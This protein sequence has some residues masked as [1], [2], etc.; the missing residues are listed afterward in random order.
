MTYNEIRELLGD[1][2]SN[3]L[4]HKCERISSDLLHKPSMDKVESIF[5]DSNRSKKVISNIKRLY[6]SG[7]LANTGYL[8]ILPVDQ[9]IEH[10]AIYS[11]YNNPIYFDPEN[12]VKL[13]IEGGTNGVVSTFGALGILSKK[14][15]D[16]IPF[17][18]KI[19][20]NELLS[21]PNMH[22][23]TMFGLVSDAYNMGATAIG[24]T[25]YFGSSDSR[26][27]IEEVSEA[28]SIAHELGMATILWCYTRNKEFVIDGVDYH[29][30]SDLSSQAIHLGATLQA[31]II[32]QKLPTINGGTKALNSKSE[33]KYSKYNED[34]DK[35]LVTENPIDMTRLQVAASYMGRIDVINSGGEQG[36]NDK[37]SAVRAAVINKR[38]GGA[39]M[40]MGRKAYKKS[41]DEGVE[42]LNMVQDVYLDEQITLS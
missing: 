31:D 10:S 12:V 11:F 33:G 32:K 22:K 36:D 38:A 21:Y 16:K 1:E 5:S 8:S 41:F 15:S 28:F 20:H 42:I 7:R 6:G 30:S 18:V 35:T 23:Q 13:A 34:M 29:T 19:N 27:Q 26:Q 40:I 2:A 37:R 3:L 14:Y 39:G 24:A 17:I 25:V 4:D 9:G